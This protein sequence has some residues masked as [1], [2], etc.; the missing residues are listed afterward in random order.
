MGPIYK[1]KGMTNGLKMDMG[2][3]CTHCGRDT[4]FASGNGLFVNRIPSMA[5]GRIELTLTDTP[6]IVELDGYLCPDCQAVSCDKCGEPTLDYEIDN[7]D[8]NIYCGECLS[9]KEGE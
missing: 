6:L 1:P 3:L 4:A 8:G 2:D 7:N 9:R 5:D